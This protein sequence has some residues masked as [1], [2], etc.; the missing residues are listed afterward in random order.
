MTNTSR[1]Q[2]AV[3]DRRLSSIWGRADQATQADIREYEEAEELR[4]ARTAAAEK[5]ENP[6]C[7]VPDCPQ[8]RCRGCRWNAR[9]P[10]T[11]PTVTRRDFEHLIDLECKQN[12]QM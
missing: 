1:R 5:R 6:A 11:K 12:P 7:P 2:A 10:Y 3:Y 4:Q 9:K 8:A